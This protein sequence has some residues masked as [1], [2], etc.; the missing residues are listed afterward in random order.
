MTLMAAFATGYRRRAEIVGLV[1]RGAVGMSTF[2]DRTACHLRRVLNPA[3][4]GIGRV[5]GSTGL[6]W[7]LILVVL[8]VA[9][10]ALFVGG[11]LCCAPCAVIQFNG[12]MTVGTVPGQEP[13]SFVGAMTGQAG[14]I[15]V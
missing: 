2:K 15:G 10:E 7:I 3:G 4:T 11:A 13:N 14:F 9:V 1:T 5:A 12:G 8:L 6:R